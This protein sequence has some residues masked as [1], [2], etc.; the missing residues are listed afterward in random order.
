MATMMEID[1]P[2]LN[3]FYQQRYNNLRL[4]NG[5]VPPADREVS[6]ASTRTAQDD[7]VIRDESSM[8]VQMVDIGTPF[9]G[10]PGDKYFTVSIDFGTTFSSVS[11]IALPMDEPNL[12]VHPEAIQSIINYPDEPSQ[13]LRDKR[14]EVP[15][16]SWYPSN[17]LGEVQ[18]EPGNT[19]MTDSNED[20][21]ED[22]HEDGGWNN[23]C[24][25]HGHSDADDEVDDDDS[26]DF[27]WGYGVQRQ[28]EFPDSNRNQ[29][30]R[31]ARSKLLL[32][33]S[34]H[35]EDVR[36]ELRP[37][38]RRLKNRKLIK[39]DEDVIAD[40]LEHLFRH[41]KEQLTTYHGFSDSC[42]LEFVLCVP[43]IWTQKACRTMQTAMETAI[44]KSE[45]GSVQNGSV[46]DLFIVS[47]PEAASAYVLAYTNEIQVCEY[48][49]WYTE[50]QG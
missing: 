4:A 28:L 48:D 50:V 41:T 19:L 7:S 39:N 2:E 36:D 21:N 37:T 30:R 33:S 24:V 12:F 35:T 29:N 25:Q 16:E 47:E 27:F 32:D 43:A 34:R 45:F 6:V 15:T 18:N 26:K 38:L 9:E 40:Y 44:R 42:P 1:N 10:V 23:S 14:R 3:T 17:P 8:E 20:P 5:N 46:E 49:P 13:G 31:V 22:A 11:F